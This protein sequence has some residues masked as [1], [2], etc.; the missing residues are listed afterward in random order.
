MRRVIAVVVALALAG[1]G[2]FF[3]VR[4]VQSAED[5]ALEGQEL[6]EV[7]VVARPIAAGTP[8]EQLLEEQVP[9][10]RVPRN[11]AATGAVVDMA[12]LAGKVA[13]IDLL[14]GEQIIRVRFVTPEEYRESLGVG[15]KVE[16]PA[17]MLQ[18]TLSLSPE[19][20]VG[21]QV[22]PGDRI[23]VFASFDPFNLN[24][25][26]PTGTGPEA[27]PVFM[28]DAEDEPS[29]TGLQSPNST[30][31]ILHKVLVTNVQAEALPRTLTDDQVVAGAP[32]LAPTGNLLITL[33][34]GP[35]SAERLVFTAEHGWIWL[36]LEGSEVS[37]ADTA[38]QT[39]GIV[40][41]AQ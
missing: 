7:R 13:A 3:L 26:E 21:G 34:L 24:F 9:L 8:V 25:E 16:V 27:I 32:E 10:R 41:E 18:V 15:P 38:I 4:F 12:T 36:A 39:R 33:A 29:R 17:D 28:P 19:R 35:A 22:K 23:A 30:K 5:R 2:T 20:V 1:S 14:P 11:V 37:E 31:I 6:V 40:Y